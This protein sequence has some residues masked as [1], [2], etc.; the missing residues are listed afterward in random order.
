[1][2]QKLKKGDEINVA[3]YFT[4]SNSM[5]SLVVNKIELKEPEPVKIAGMTIR[6]MESFKPAT[7][8]INLIDMFHMYAPIGQNVIIFYR[9]FASEEQPY[10]IV[11]NP[12]T[13]KRIEITL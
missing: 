2:A 4:K 3:G 8:N 13:G 7:Y 1:M 12:L 5:L 9:K 6:E 10:I 11:A